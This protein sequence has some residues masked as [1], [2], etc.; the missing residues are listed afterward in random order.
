MVLILKMVDELAPQVVAAPFRAPVPT[1]FFCCFSLSKRTL[2]PPLSLGF[3]AHGEVLSYVCSLNVAL[4]VDI[5]QV[6]FEVWAFVAH[7]ALDYT[8]PCL[9]GL[10]HPLLFLNPLFLHALHLE[11]HV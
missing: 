10:P 5:H 7:V 1:S 9:P 4:C 2:G 11:E 6:A 8:P 3:E